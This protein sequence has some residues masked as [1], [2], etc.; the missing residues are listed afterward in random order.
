M[1]SQNTVR[2]GKRNVRA[3]AV[4]GRIPVVVRLDEERYEQVA[5]VAERNESSMGGACAFLIK[6]ALSAR[7]A[8]EAA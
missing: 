5:A 8:S 7:E 4:A 3:T 2:R 6:Q 1:A